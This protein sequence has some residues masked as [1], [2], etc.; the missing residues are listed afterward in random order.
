LISF[1]LHRE[2]NYTIWKR[3][4]VRTIIVCEEVDDLQVFHIAQVL[5]QISATLSTIAHLVLEISV[6][7]D[8]RLRGMDNVEWLPLLHQFPAVQT[9]HV[10]RKIAEHVALALEDV[11]GELVAE[12]LPSL[13]L[14]YLEGHP[15]SSVKKFVAARQLAGRPVTVLETESDFDERHESYYSK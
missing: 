4:S 6:D 15:A 1:Y 14:I 9:L 2:A 11:T 5:S 13:N 8:N 12:V 7:S 10:Y 3:P